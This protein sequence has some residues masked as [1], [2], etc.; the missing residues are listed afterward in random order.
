MRKQKKNLL[1]KPLRKIAL[2][3]NPPLKEWK[4]K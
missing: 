1:F 4:E 2:H 3:K